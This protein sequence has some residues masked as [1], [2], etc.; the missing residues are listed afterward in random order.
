MA[1]QQ[2][3]KK[4]A[5][6]LGWLIA[7]VVILVLAVGSMFLAHKVI[8]EEHVH[9]EGA[10]PETVIDRLTNPR[11]VELFMDGAAAALMQEHKVP[12]VT[13]SIVKNGDL[14]FA[15]GYG[16]AD[17]EKKI[18][19][20]SDKTLFRPGSVS[21]LFVWTAVMQL[22]EQG[23]LDLKADVNSYLK[24]FKIPATYPQPVTME[25]ILT[26]TAGFEDTSINMETYDATSILP[27]G[28]YLAEN[29]PARVRPPHQ[30]PSY[31]NYASALAGYIVGQISGMPYEKY[32]E[33]HILKPLEMTH[34]T[35]VQPLPKDLA[36]D[37]SGGYLWKDGIYQSQ[38]FECIVA[39]PAGAACTT[40]NDMAKFMIMHLANGRY[41]DTWVLKEKTALLMHQR[42]FGMD[43]RLNGICY[44]FFQMNRN[45]QRIIG[46]DGATSFF[47]TQMALLLEK[48]VGLF[49]ST[50][51][52]GGGKL[53]EALYKAFLDRYYPVPPVSSVK[54]PADFMKRAKKYAGSYESIRRAEKTYEKFMQI[55]GQ[56]KVTV[57]PQGTLQIPEAQLVE[58]SPDYFRKVD[59]QETVFFK[60]DKSGKVRYLCLNSVPALVFDK[61]QWYATA[62]FQI[63]CL[64]VIV[65]ICIAALIGWPIGGF[66]HRTKVQPEGAP[67]RSSVPYT[68]AWVN[69]MLFMSG[70]FGILLH[71]LMLGQG[72]LPELS[73][74][75]ICLTLLLAAS[76]L[77][78]VTVV[79]A[80][81]LWKDKAGTLMGRLRY[82]VVTLALAAFIY[83]L[84]YWNLIGYKM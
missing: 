69:I 57:T 23:K 72:G 25:D 44:G 6:G 64:A 16:Y 19:V 42:H 26:H 60:E 39:A 48:N 83:W 9:E 77:T 67:R 12:G 51:S 43:E 27:L 17:L 70:Y 35:F 46:H 62:C 38:Q 71:T 75:R 29:M 8:I 54:P 40:A 81:K 49:V 34:T 68:I 61:K 18:P 56:I 22:V 13:V 74:I 80:V 37:M 59:G 33:E 65:L 3:K 1:K 28:K 4:K 30:L 73:Y 5:H 76:L 55:F 31:S 7:G 50:N 79:S 15:K 2:K 52:S 82:T 32:I 45:N 58:I 78:I 63:S 20:I 11:D 36:P 41:K 84:H 53:A 21:K 47:M 14:F 24:D 10:A 66:F